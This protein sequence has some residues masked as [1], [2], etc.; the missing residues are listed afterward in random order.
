MHPTHDPSCVTINLEVSPLYGTPNFIPI[1]CYIAFQSS[2]ETMADLF[3]NNVGI[4]SEIMCKIVV[5]FFLQL[6]P[7]VEDER[8][9]ANFS[10]V[11][12]FF[13]DK[14]VTFVGCDEGVLCFRTNVDNGGD[15]FKLWNPVT[16]QSVDVGHPAGLSSGMNMRCGFGYDH[17]TQEF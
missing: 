14:M 2:F 13:C 5:P 12:N 15:R 16:C 10:R 17:H 11:P 3:A 9:L 7:V 1:H 8:T 6:D 4:P